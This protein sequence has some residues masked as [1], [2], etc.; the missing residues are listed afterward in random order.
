[1]LRRLVITYLLPLAAILPFAAAVTSCSHT[2]SR[3]MDR[4]LARA[5]SLM[6]D[7]PDSA[8]MLLEHIGAPLP[9]TSDSLSLGSSARKALYALLLTQARHKNYIDETD[10][11]LIATAVD[12]F[13][14][15]RDDARLM[16]SLYYLATIDLYAENYTKAM[17]CAMQA[18]KLATDTGDTYWQ[19]RIYELI[20]NIFS[21]T[22]LFEEAAKNYGIAAKLYKEVDSIKSYLY[23]LSNL[24]TEQCNLGHNSQ[25]L[26]LVDSINSQT[27][28]NYLK[29][30]CTNLAISSLYNSKDYRKAKIFADSL[31][32]YSDSGS[33]EIHSYMYSNIASIY[34]LSGDT[35]SAIPLIEN[36]M[37]LAK[38]ANDTLAFYVATLDISRARND[39]PSANN[40][41]SKILSL[42]N[43]ITN[44]IR[45]QSAITSQRDYFAIENA[46]SQLE[47]TQRRYNNI[48]IAS[49]AILIIVSLIFTYRYK[50]RSKD[51]IIRDKMTEI[52][53]LTSEIEHSSKR[54]G[55]LGSLVDDSMKRQEQLAQLSHSLLKKRLAQ[56]NMLINQF[57]ESDGSD[58]SRYSI[59]KN[60]ETEFKRI[61]D[62][63]NLR[64]IES[65]VNSFLDNVVTR[66]REQL[67]DFSSDDISFLTLL[68]AG[69]ESRA[70]SIFTGF[71]PNSTYTK[72]TRL[73]AKIENSSAED[74]D[75]FIRCIH[76]P[77][78]H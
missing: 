23:A 42:Q 77:L 17:A 54:I 35:A 21:E 2:R 25:V 68:I 12:Y 13:R 52:V 9:G 4:R 49:L 56:L 30:L 20:A 3:E 38:T 69:F 41:L 40:A 7:H 37:S 16:K 48:I 51:R 62:K 39:L 14:Y 24:A 53:L 50:L 71:K 15:H 44:Q 22:Y 29:A 10:D 61:T 45:Q 19:A 58:Q 64:E 57:Y 72:K 63:K 36:A 32:Q 26:A 78:A 65:I 11:S 55:D 5:E 59:Y 43:S 31:F 67:D 74:K 76:N 46:N 28:D 33:Y 47:A 70:I 6:N 60:I 73:I 66:M 34:I 18:Q 1:M 8:L 75:F 27:S